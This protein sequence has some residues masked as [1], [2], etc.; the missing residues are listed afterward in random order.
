MING[1]S[2]LQLLGKTLVD[3]YISLKLSGIYSESILGFCTGTLGIRRG[4]QGFSH[5]YAGCLL[6]VHG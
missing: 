3:A 2:P 1:A 5:L 6:F 4:F